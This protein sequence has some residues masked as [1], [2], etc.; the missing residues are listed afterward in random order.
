MRPTY[1][2]TRDDWL[3]AATAAVVCWALIWFLCTPENVRRLARVDREGAESVR[4]DGWQLAGWVAAWT[5]DLDPADSAAAGPWALGADLATLR[6]VLLALLVGL[7]A[8][9][10]V[11]TVPPTSRRWPM[12]LAAGWALAMAAV[13]VVTG[14]VALFAP[15]EAATGSVRMDRGLWVAFLTGAGAPLVGAF[16]LVAVAL[17]VAVAAAARRFAA[18]AAPGRTGSGPPSAGVWPDRRGA[19]WAT[20]A[21][22][23]VVV[24]ALA[25]LGSTAF[26]S[27][28]VDFGDD[29]TPRLPFGV[30]R[31]LL[32]ASWDVAAEAATLD[33]LVPG[34]ATV[35]GA[36]LQVPLAAGAF[37]WAL[38]TLPRRSPPAVLLTAV[39]TGVFASLAAQASLALVASADDAHEW[40]AVTVVSMIPTYVPGAAVTAVPAGLA[41][42]LVLRRRPEPAAPAEGSED[43]DGGPGA[44]GGPDGPDDELVITVTR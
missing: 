5:R 1:R 18:P 43:P 12:T 20:A 4:D 19:W 11:R 41:A 40:T 32:P 7:A 25:G 28:A 23:G 35:L 9:W 29:E 38:R 6:I 16:A 37:W 44:P 10:A 2:P 8:G 21:F 31:W 24:A 36:V 15:M 33:G 13:M 27:W 14:A 30:T 42:W 3:P 34:Y 26:L 39:W 22:A 17:A